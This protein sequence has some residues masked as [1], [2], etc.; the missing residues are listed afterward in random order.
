MTSWSGLA[1]PAGLPDAIT[2]QLNA[3]VRR[4]IAVPEVKARL[5]SLGGEAS[6]WECGRA[7]HRCKYTVTPGINVPAIRTRAEQ[8]LTELLA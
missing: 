1:A 5:E 8:T 3:E 2:K 7:A 6:G 4:P